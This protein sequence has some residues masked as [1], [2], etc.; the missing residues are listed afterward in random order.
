MYLVLKYNCVAAAGRIQRSN[1]IRLPDSYR[2]SLPFL[3]MKKVRNQHS[4]G[5]NKAIRHLKINNIR[6]DI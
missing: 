6:I 4:R 1:W 2:D 5:K 3:A